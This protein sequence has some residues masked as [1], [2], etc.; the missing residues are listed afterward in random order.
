MD[1]IAFQPD[2][3][4]HEFIYAANPTV[5]G[6]NK[7]EVDQEILSYVDE[8]L[9]QAQVIPP[10][11]ILELGCGMGNLAIP[12]AR[13]GFQ[14]VGIDIS[15]TAIEIA[16]QRAL[17]AAGHVCFR[18]G[19]VI[20]SEAYH[21]SETFD[22]IL[23]GLCWHCIIGQDR[24]ALL[25]CVRKALKPEGCFLIITMCGDPRSPQLQTRFDPRS[26]YIISGRV[27]ERYLGR[28]QDLVEELREAGFEIAY[29]RSVI[30]NSE[31]GNQDMFLAVT[32]IC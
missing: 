27:A 8:L 17:V 6:W 15:A 30:G 2:Y 14:M 7:A 22:C 18:L 4:R 5:S 13:A 10:A 20:S 21:D 31:T 32:R 12:L 11:R 16:T 25:A 3:L 28:P 1:N 23:D 29:H 9:H 26:R 24:K 19:N